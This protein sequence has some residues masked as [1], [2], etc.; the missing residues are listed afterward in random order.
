MDGNVPRLRRVLRQTGVDHNERPSRRRVR[1]HL[2]RNAHLM[3]LGAWMG[4]PVITGPLEHWVVE[5]VRGQRR[6]RFLHPHQAA[7]V[8]QRRERTRVGRPGA[9][10]RAEEV[11]R[12]IHSRLLAA[13]EGDSECRTPSVSSDHLSAQNPT[14]G[15][16]PAAPIGERRTIPNVAEASS[17]DESCY[18]RGGRISLYVAKLES[19]VMAADACTNSAMWGLATWASN[20][21]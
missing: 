12:L 5:R 11:R 10:S 16:R 1:R 6:P 21:A 7:P 3:R 8:P 20:A 17:C 9:G 4:P 19:A 18:D 14:R 15:F 2:F 13:S